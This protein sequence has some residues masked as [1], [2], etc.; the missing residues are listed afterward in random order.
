MPAEAIVRFTK[1]YAQYNVG[2]QAGYTAAQ[3]QRL[4]DSGIAVMVPQ[5]RAAAKKSV[6]AGTEDRSMQDKQTEDK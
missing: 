6:P 1:K 4:V 5:G 3:A 2:E